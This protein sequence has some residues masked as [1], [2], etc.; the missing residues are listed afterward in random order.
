MSTSSWSRMWR[1]SGVRVT[2]GAALAVAFCFELWRHLAAPGDFWTLWA[3]ARALAAGGDPYR[4]GALAAAA[5]LPHGLRPGPF[6]SPLFVAEA[7]APLGALPFSLARALW[8]GLNLALAVWLLWLLLGQAG[9]RPTARAWAAGAAL[10]VAFQPFDLTLWLG[11]TDIV[12]VVALALAWRW[13]KGGRPILAG[14][15]ASVAAIDVHLLAGFGLYLLYRACAKRDHRP[16]LG[17][18]A[19]LGL[20]GGASLLHAGDVGHWLAV[21]LP[22][23]QAAAIEPWDTL[24]GL[25]AATELLGRHAA[26]AAVAA[27]DAAMLLLAWRAWRGAGA[28]PERDLAVAAVLTLAT[29]TFAYNQ[30][31]LLLVLAAPF[32]IRQWRQGVAP[33]RTGAAALCLC[34][35]FGLAELTASPVSPRHAGFML[36]APLLALTLALLLR[37]GGTPLAPAHRAWAWIW[38]GV[39]LGGYALLAVGRWEVAPELLLL[40]GLVGFLLLTGVA[41]GAPPRQG[42]PGLRGAAAAA[43]PPRACLGA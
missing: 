30:D 15:V 3:A 33:W 9:V 13:L 35:G 19:G 28:G 16:L 7:F 29:T 41:D 11:Q 34:L 43:E 26:W 6:L 36:G 39:T 40:G 22:H 38:A 31:Y 37:G 1:W 27:L 14:L 32:L 17:L 25:Q 21:T 2:C 24:S 23:A 12:V 5:A 4:F 42:A 18:A 10:L 8:L 20:L